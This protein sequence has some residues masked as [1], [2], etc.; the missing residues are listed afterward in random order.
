M[1]T[2]SLLAQILEQPDAPQ[3]AEQ[4]QQVLQEERKRRE[5]FYNEI[6]EQQKAEFI[7]G[8]VIIHSPVKRLHNEISVNLIK[9]LDTFVVKHD[10]GF[11][12]IE[13]IMIS[14]TRNDYEPDICFFRK[15]VAETF[16]PEQVL[17]PVP[18]FI[19]EILSKNT[20]R[21]DKG[22]KFEDY[23]YHGVKE[24]WIIDPKKKT[25]EQYLLQRG[26]YELVFKANKGDLESPVLKGFSIPVEAIFDKKANIAALT[27]LLS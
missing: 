25:I 4:L 5:A 23:Q 15:E 21:N 8:E 12:G 10:L 17:F 6:T 26:K 14:L 3:L 27:R 11:V 1:S 20:A 22:V 2:S 9:L 13:K 18:D 24:Y 19:I 16:E 7:N